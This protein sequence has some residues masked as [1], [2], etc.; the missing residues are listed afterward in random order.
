MT[1]RTGTPPPDVPL[2]VLCWT[3]RGVRES[4]GW[5]S[6]TGRYVLSTDGTTVTRILTPLQV[7]G[8]RRVVQESF[9][10]DMEAGA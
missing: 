2:I 4:R 3:R 6:R 5:W 10:T 1:F 8:W 7:A 9:P